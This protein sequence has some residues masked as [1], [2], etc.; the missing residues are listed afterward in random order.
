MPRLREMARPKEELNTYRERMGAWNDRIRLQLMQKDPR[1]KTE[2]IIHVPPAVMT[3]GAI[4][5]KHPE[6][7]KDK[8][9]IR[10]IY[11]LVRVMQ[12][13]QRRAKNSEFEISP[14]E[15]AWIESY[16]VLKES[17]VKQHP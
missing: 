9:R 5:L 11:R 12:E 10:Q 7:A 8:K 15:G 1:R 6:I 14:K 4:I 2:S 16:K 17:I 3:T 13:I